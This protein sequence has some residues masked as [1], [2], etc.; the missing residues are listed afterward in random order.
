M[1]SDPHG[2]K[3]IHTRAS[4]HGSGAIIVLKGSDSMMAAPNGCTIINANAPPIL[5]TAGLG[6]VL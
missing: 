1:L 6:D 5:A 3:P 2:D 4:A